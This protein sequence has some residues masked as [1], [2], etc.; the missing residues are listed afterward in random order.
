VIIE[1]AVGAAGLLGLR[2]LVHRAILLGLRAPRLAHAHGPGADE[3][4]G[5]RVQEVDLIGPGGKRLFGWF[6]RPDPM[7]GHPVP[8]VLVMHGWGANASTMWPVASPLARAGLAVL[9]V[10]ARCHGRSDDEAFTSLPRFAEDI[11]AGLAWLRARPDVDAARLA[12]L[13]HSVGAG[14]ALLHAA[15][16]GG[17]RAVVSVSAFAHPREV[18]RRYLADKGVPFPVLG[19]YVLRRV[20]RVIGVSFDD[21]AP[22]ASIARVQCPVLLV[23]GR[24]DTTVPVGD[25]LR[26]HAAAA[27]ADLLLVEGDHDLRD[28]LG[29]HA[30]VVIEF[31]AT[32]FT[33]SCRDVMHWS[34]LTSTGVVPWSCPPRR[35]PSSTTN[36]TCSNDACRLPGARS[37]NSDAAPQAWRVPCWIGIRRAAWSDWRWTSANMRR[38]SPRPVLA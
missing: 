17:L 9:F 36:S 28:A 1:M 16:E 26:L 18:M 34:S 10:D 7:C 8:A 11:A 14:A 33:E 5:V 15:R 21:I 4:M 22:I 37:S 32:A 24:V 35:C 19:W 29:N 38:T 27:N 2:W 3:P 31:L 13:G 6:V 23:H 20:Q 12:V 25:A 30:E